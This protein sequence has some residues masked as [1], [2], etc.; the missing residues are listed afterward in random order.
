MGTLFRTPLYGYKILCSLTRVYTYRIAAA[1]G[2][3]G[4]ENR[5]YLYSTHLVLSGMSNWVSSLI[6]GPS[7]YSS[8]RTVR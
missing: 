2:L 6:P 1:S 5:I 7:V 8:I 3:R 4:S